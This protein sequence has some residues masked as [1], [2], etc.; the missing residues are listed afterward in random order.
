[1]TSQAVNLHYLCYLQAINCQLQ[2]A[3]AQQQ[4][5]FKEFQTNINHRVAKQHPECKDMVD[6]QSAQLKDRE[7]S[8]VE[9][10]KQLEI[11]QQSM[12]DMLEAEKK[13]L[14]EH[15]LCNVQEKGAAQEV[16]EFKNQSIEENHGDWQITGR[17]EDTDEVEECRINHSDKRLKQCRVWERRVNIYQCHITITQGAAEIKQKTEEEDAPIWAWFTDIMEKLGADGMS[18]DESMTEDKIHVVYC[19]KIMLWR[20]DLE[21]E[22]GILNSQQLHIPLK[23]DD[24]LGQQVEADTNPQ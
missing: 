21:K 10:R 3:Q 11:D 8:I 20:R 16:F 22:M 23:M 1:M 15:N 17:I 18:S 14:R 5:A 2:D 24:S 19:T 9:M 7:E 6:I 4:R 13:R 12:K